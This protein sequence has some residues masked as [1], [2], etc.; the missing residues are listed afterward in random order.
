M[1]FEPIDISHKADVDLAYKSS[2][3]ESADAVFVN[4]WLWRFSREISIARYNGFVIIAQRSE[5]DGLQFLMPMGNGDL[6]EVISALIVKSRSEGFALRFSVVTQTDKER[7]EA[8]CPERFTFTPMPDKNDYLYD[9]QSLIKLG[10]RS[11]HAKK[12]FVNRFETMYGISYEHLSDENLEETIGFVCRWFERAP[13]QAE[14]ER[15]G[16]VEM[17]KIYRLF[18]CSY[19]ILRAE[20]EIAAFTI[21]E[22]L[23]PDRVVIHV[24][25][26]DGAN[27]PGSYQTINNIHLERDWADMKVVNREEDL[28]IEGLRK[29]KLSYHPIDFVHKYEAVLN[30]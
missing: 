5:A 7:L 26:A 4:L 15:V 25:K 1:R 3:M 24:E 20:G 21:G 9:C 29:A 17:L 27:Y 14:A 13:Y 19:G 2:S 8:T 30:V 16:I 6:N 28:G 18:A 22:A 12:N 11:Y 10:G 23:S